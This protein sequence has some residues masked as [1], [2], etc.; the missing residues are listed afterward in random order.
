M[1]RLVVPMRRREESD[2]VAPG[3]DVDLYYLTVGDDGMVYASVFLYTDDGEGQG[4]YVGRFDSHGFFTPLFYIGSGPWLAFYTAFAVTGGKVFVITHTISGF[5]TIHRY[6]MTGSLEASQELPVRYAVLAGAADGSVWTVGPQYE[7]VLPG[8]FSLHTEDHFY[9]VDPDTLSV[10]STPDVVLTV[11]SW[12]NETGAGGYNPFNV[13]FL[14]TDA[15]V[16]RV[17]RIGSEDDLYS[18]GYSE[19][20]TV[21]NGTT[22][23]EFYLPQVD[24]L[25][26]DPGSPEASSFTYTGAGD[27]FSR[28]TGFTMYRY[29]ASD[30]YSATAIERSELLPA[31]SP[32]S[33]GEFDDPLTSASRII[34]AND[35]YVYTW[36]WQE[37]RLLRYTR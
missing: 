32:E 34:T 16:V 20:V 21:S 17:A 15:G 13:A 37:Q 22:S 36:S 7:L 4:D 27:L 8:G 23:D 12:A 18:D 1:G 2:W 29:D 26:G 14:A 24:D 25:N 33:S 28:G 19:M 31:P 6:S 9:A 35:T 10:G 5:P 30:S 3:V 11:P